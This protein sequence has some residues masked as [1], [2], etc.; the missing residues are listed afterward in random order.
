MG[1][2]QRLLLLLMFLALLVECLAYVMSKWGGYSSYPIYHIYTVVEYVFLM[3]IFSQTVTSRIFSRIL[4]FS[5]PLFGLFALLNIVL[6]QPLNEPNTN[7]TILTSII[8]VIVAVSWFFLTLN[9][10]RYSRIE[11]S[12]AFWI[13]VGVLIYFSSSIVLFGFGNRLIEIE[14]VDSISVWV[15]HILFNMIHYLCFNIALWMD[16]E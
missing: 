15:I 11:K 13:C 3:Q 8:M 16:P 12:S 14:L 1:V 2:V 6:W 10:M 7:A 9:E 5:V 4:R